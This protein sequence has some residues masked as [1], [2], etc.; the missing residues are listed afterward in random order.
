MSVREPLYLHEYST[1]K[2]YG[3][4]E[5]KKLKLIHIR[6]LETPVLNWMPSLNLIRR[7]KSHA[8]MMKREQS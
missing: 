4:G 1:L 2:L 8:R 5:N 3:Y 6:V 7:I